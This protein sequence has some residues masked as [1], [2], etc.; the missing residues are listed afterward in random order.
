MFSDFVSNQQE[1]IG[2]PDEVVLPFFTFIRKKREV[3]VKL[4]PPP[5]CQRQI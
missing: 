2:N 3:S 1:N 4:P 5:I